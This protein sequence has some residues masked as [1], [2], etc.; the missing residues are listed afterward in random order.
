MRKLLTLVALV[1]MVVGAK[2]QTE[3]VI[4]PKVGMNVT[5]LSSLDLKEKVS[6]HVGGFAEFRFSDYFAV[7]PELI[8]SRQGARDKNDGTKMIFRANY[9]NIP[10]LFR[11]YVLDQLSVDLG[12]EFGFALNARYK[13]KANKNTVTDMDVNT[14]SFAFAMGVSYN[15]DNLMFSA[16]YNLG[17]SNAIDKK[18]VDGGNKNHVFQL[19][20]GYRFGDL[21]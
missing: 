3:I 20:V 2:A 14:L 8:Y 7:Q 6:F 15:W 9:L 17:L 16:R 19:S 11:C 10:V 18:E 4:G 12:P 1:C 21:F 5:N 13:V